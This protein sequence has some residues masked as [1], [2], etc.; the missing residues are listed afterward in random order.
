M[1]MSSPSEDA[2]PEGPVG[3]QPLSNRSAVALTVATNYFLLLLG[4]ATSVVAARLLGPNGRGELAAI[5]LWPQQLSNI[6][7]LGLPEALVYHSSRWGRDL[8]PA[9]ATAAAVSLG[10]ALALSAVGFVAMPLLLDSQA[11]R[12]V[13]ASRLYLL[14]TVFLIGTLPIHVLRGKSQFRTWNVVRTLAPAAWLGVLAVAW[15]LAKHDPVFVA[16]GNL[17]VTAAL[18]VPV[19][20]IA[21][22]AAPGPYRPRREYVRPLLTF[23]LPNVLAVLPQTLNLRLD[24]M[25]LAAA[26]P[27]DQ[28]GFYVTAVAWST[29]ITPAVYAIAHV[30]FPRIA[31]VASADRVQVLLRGVRMSVLVGV[32][33]GSALAAAT[34]F[35]LPLA[36]GSSFSPAVP[37]ALVLI[38]AA[39][40]SG[41]N[42]VLQDS[43]RGL[44]LPKLVLR[45][46]LAGLVVTG[47]SLAVLLPQFGL[48]GTA[49]ASLIGYS[50]VFVVLVRL[51]T[52]ATDASVVE[53]LRPSGAELAQLRRMASGGV[54][55]I[56]RLRGRR[57]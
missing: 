42:F 27:S 5:M 12:I 48:I 22:R 32:L 37:V 36:F 38:A 52:K 56:V 41:C 18:C 30:N 28:L 54:R 17:L 9:M 3:T 14:L 40:V 24:Q 35:L 7:L 49:C 11:P 43:L 45:S 25:I 29:A 20:L 13:A 1:S 2:P 26:L 34:P 47:V 57:S 44:G 33:T 31:D 19:L 53:L 6:A 51:T 21:R 15:V 10:A 8:G 23:G 39:I 16:E 46:E 4:V 55:A 50:G